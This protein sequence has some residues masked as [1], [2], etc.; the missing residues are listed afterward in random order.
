MCLAVQQRMAV[1]FLI[2]VLTEALADLQEMLEVPEP[3]NS[4]PEGAAVQGPGS[5]AEVVTALQFWMSGPYKISRGEA[6]KLAGGQHSSA[7]EASSQ[8]VNNNSKQSS[9]KRGPSDVLTLE[10]IVHPK[11]PCRKYTG[12]RYIWGRS[13]VEAGDGN[14]V[15][16]RVFVGKRDMAET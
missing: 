11:E 16:R 8:E 12:T 10:S 5:G 9:N 13:C 3:L 14:T 4:S 6:G 15:F 7:R 1:L 2:S